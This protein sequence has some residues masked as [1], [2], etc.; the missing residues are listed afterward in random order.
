MNTSDARLG[1]QIVDV[2]MDDKTLTADLADGRKISV[3]FS[4]FPRL[5]LATPAARANW[6]LARG[7]FG[8]TWPDID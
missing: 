1:E 8:I 3:P 4:S 7:G 6:R 2:H 5:L